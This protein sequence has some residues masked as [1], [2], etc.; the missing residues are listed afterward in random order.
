MII[1]KDTTLESRV[2][3]LPDGLTIAA[4]N[5]TLDGNGAILIGRDR[6]GIGIKLE[7]Q[8]HVT[9]RNLRILEFRFGIWAKDCKALSVKNCTINATF[10]LAP[11]EFFLNIWEK[12]NSIAG[13]GI[14]LWNASHALIA[15]NNL[16]HQLY[17]LAAFHSKYLLVQDNIANYN[18]GA[19]FHIHETSESQFIGNYADYC[20]RYED[21]GENTGHMGG[22]AAGFT[23]VSNSVRNVFRRNFARLSGDGFLLAGLNPEL[24][25]VG[26]HNNLF[27][28]NDASWAPNIAFEATFSRGNIFRS[29]KANNCNYGFW[30]GFSTEN[31]LEG[32]HMERNRQAGIAAENATF[33]RV[34]GNNFLRNAHGILLWSKYI[35]NF[36]KAFPK[37]DTSY[38]WEITANRFNSNEIALR[39]AA[40]Q[41]HGLRPYRSAG[42]CPPP[43]DHYIRN[44][45]FHHNFTAIELHSVMQ[46]HIENNDTEGN[47]L[48][49]VE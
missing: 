33:I 19:G 44:N 8:N 35:P 26:C 47:L 1:D 9:I 10:E 48:D 27:E 37:N 28:E 38:Q 40:D 17:G 21:R 2:Y 25:K 23:I 22:D 11:N 13:A 42:T 45:D 12:P 39:I 31:K 29:N 32:N 46:T 43:R 3:Y 7:G 41:D 49:L 16:Q 36:I 20:T 34:V 30:L 18:S 5:I 15:E 14:L 6:T 24:E 4:E